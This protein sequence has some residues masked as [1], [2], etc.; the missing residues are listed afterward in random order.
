[1]QGQV[2]IRCGH[3]PIGCSCIKAKLEED[4]RAN[5]LT[6]EAIVR[7]PKR[8]VHWFKSRMRYPSRYVVTLLWLSLLSIV[9]CLSGNASPAPRPNIIFILADDLGYGDV[10]VFHQNQRK[11][12]GDRSKPWHQ[13]PN[14]DR[15]AAEGVTLPHHYSAAPVC[16]PARA[17][18]LTGLHQGHANIR[19]NQFDKILE[20]NHNLAT[21]VK[22]AGYATASIGKWGLAGEAPAF[23][24]HP[25]NRGFDH[26]FGGLRH[27]DGHEHY[28]KEGSYRG[29]RHVWENRVDV[30]SSLDKCYTTDLYTA[31]AKQWVRQHHEAKP[32]QPFFLYLSYD[33]PHAVAELPTQPYPTGGGLHGGLQWLGK[34]GQMINTASGEIDSWIHPE[35]AI[36]TWDDDKNPNT[37]E[38]A[39]PNVYQ[40]YATSVRR[41]DDAVGDLIQQL[42][43]LKLDQNTLIVFTSDN[44]PSVESYLKEAYS[45]EFFGSYGPFSGI[46]RDLWEGGIRVGAIARWPAAI[47]PERNCDLPSAHWDWLATFAELTGRPAPARTDGH[48][49]LPSL[50]NTGKQMPSKIYSEYAV[51]GK[52]PNFHDFPTAIQNRPRGQMQVLR[53]GELSSIRLAITDSETPF[54]IYNVVTDPRQAINLAPQYVELQQQLQNDVLRMRRPLSDAPRPYDHALVPAVVVKNPVMGNLD[55]AIYQGTWPWLPDCNTLRPSFKGRGSSLKPVELSRMGS[56]VIRFHGYFHAARDGLY[57]FHL[58]SSGRSQLRL[59]DALV[60]D[61]DYHH[62]DL[63]VN[64][65]IHLEAGYHPL[66]LDCSGTI[67]FECEGPEM[68]RTAIISKKHCAASPL[69]NNSYLPLEPADGEAEITLHGIPFLKSKTPRNLVPGIYPTHATLGAVVLAGMTTAK[70]E[71]SERW[72][73]AEPAHAFEG[74]LFIGDRVGRVIVRYGD[75]TLEQV[76]VIFGVNL[77]PYE[78]YSGAGPGEKE[79]LTSNALIAGPYREPFASDPAAAKLLSD[80]LRTLENADASK[81]LRYLMAVRLRPVPLKSIELIDEGLR[82]AGWQVGAISGLAIGTPPPA[83][84]PLLDQ[85]FFI[86]QQHLVPAEALAR[87]LYQYED[88]LPSKVPFP[89]PTKG[90]PQLLFEGP[91]A[92]AILSNVFSFNARDLVENKLTSQGRLASSSP[93]AVNFG[94]YIGMGTWRKGVGQYSHHSWSRDAGPALRELLA[95][96]R[97]REARA[98]GEALLRYLYDGDLR[99]G[100]P[101]WKRVINAHEVGEGEKRKNQRAENDGHAAIMLAMAQL[102]TSPAVDRA[103]IDRNWSAFVDAGD[104]FPWQISHPEISAFDGL[105]YNESESSGGGGRDLYSNAQATLALRA[106]A[107]LADDYGSPEKT[108]SWNAAATRIES[109]IS[110]HLTLPASATD[111]LSPRYIDTDTLLDSWAYGWKRMAPLLANADLAGFTLPSTP[112]EARR[113][114]NTYQQLRGPGAIAPDA[115]RTLGYGQAYFAQSALLLDHTADA[116]RAVERAAAFCYHPDHPFIVPEGVIVHPDGHCWF[117]NGD[118]GNL[119]QQTEVLKMIRIMAGIDDRATPSGLTLIPRLPNGWSSI[120]A[121]EWPVRVSDSDGLWTRV[122]IDFRYERLT[123]GGYR[124]RMS[125]QKPLSIASIRIGPYPRAGILPSYQ[126]AKRWRWSQEGD[127]WFLHADEFSKPLDELEWEFP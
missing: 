31:R 69:K 20:D 106:F 79:L 45:P 5:N 2:L 98:A 85:E 121:K 11:D 119:M 80:S 8:S 64:A 14:I 17:S 112:G 122:S 96:G 47:P 67:E 108:K 107:K 12:S 46:K 125:S 81:S 66:L 93:G 90:Y 103:W 40:R 56:H 76:P 54:E 124:L 26:Y 89:Q 120:E 113:L 6:C 110:E 58:K 60:I 10:G 34:P 92:A 70:A 55:H 87:R 38:V 13:T 4:R 72:G 117:R 99:H 127:G 82:N 71:G 88:S 101:N 63:W 39:W 95:L 62:S 36:A 115:G 7:P 29:P 52:T 73:M 22:S 61:N 59:H 27:I 3:V 24:G 83:G 49:L 116:T 94:G 75:D 118:L 97:D 18:L 105:L 35:Y 33:T 21:I 50:T 57:T 9:T 37:P 41:I 53:T 104:W 23:P 74:R 1:M 109:A 32:N 68:P 44:G 126:Q 102:A 84:L 43:D 78:L 114:S 123:T 28:P 86:R 15:L 65:S 19:D 111:S 30:T 48:S 77:W 25:L 100:R 42:K 16:A 51:S 91:P